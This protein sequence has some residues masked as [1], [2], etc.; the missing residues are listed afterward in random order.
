MRQQVA[1]MEELEINR[2]KIY[3][4]LRESKEKHRIIPENMD[5]AYYEVDLIG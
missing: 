2:R 5:D 4:A 1:Q 3:H